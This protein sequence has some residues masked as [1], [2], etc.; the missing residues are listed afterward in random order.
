MDFFVCFSS[1]ASLL[2]SRGQ[3]NYAAANAF[4]DTFAHYRRNQG[5][6]GLSINWGP[7]AEAGMAAEMDSRAKR[8][9]Q[10]QGWAPI[11]PE[12]GMRVLG[13]LLSQNVSQ[14]GVLP[15]NWSKFLEQFPTNTIPS[16]FAE[17]AA[18]VASV[19]QTEKPSGLQHEFLQNLRDMSARGRRELLVKYLQDLVARIIGLAPG[20][21]PN[22]QQLFN[23]LG[24]D[25]LMQMELRNHITTDLKVNVPMAEFISRS[26]IATLTELLLE[27]LAL[28][29][30]TLDRPS[31][32]GHDE[33]MEEISL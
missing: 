23:E 30:V 4:L 12:Q 26:N 13:E 1:A 33:D 15:L 32:D 6:A 8:R 28:A 5:L 9:M 17:W 3:G 29:S 21:P 31:L 2:G 25:S 16:Y 18:P 14:V 11:S 19:G 22:P 20:Q 10:E 7:W 24:L 27:Y